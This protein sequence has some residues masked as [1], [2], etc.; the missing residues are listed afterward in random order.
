MAFDDAT[1]TF[2]ERFKEQ[3]KI[4]WQDRGGVSDK[5]GKYQVAWYSVPVR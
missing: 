4:A 5:K 2:K 1:R 3:T